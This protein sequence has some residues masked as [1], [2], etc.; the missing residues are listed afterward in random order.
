[1]THNIPDDTLNSSIVYCINE[2]VR[3][4][5]DR[6]ILRE[7]WFQGMSMQS[8][9]EKHDLSITGVKKILYNVG[10]KILLRAQK[11]RES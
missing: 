4:E 7:H 2:Y 3:L 10:D 1:M 5:R 11:M 8:I 9:A 6:E